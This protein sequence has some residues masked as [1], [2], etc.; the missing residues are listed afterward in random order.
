VSGDGRRLATASLDGAVRVWSL[1]GGAAAGPPIRL[2]YLVVSVRLSPDGRTLL[3]TD[4]TG[5]VRLWDAETS[6]PLGL[7]VRHGAGER[8]AAD[9]EPGLWFHEAAFL[10]DRRGWV[11]A[12]MDGAAI[13][14]DSSLDS[15]DDPEAL[16]E[17]AEAVAGLEVGGDGRLAAA[18]DPAARLRDLRE[19]AA[20]GDLPLVRWFLS[21]PWE[22][23]VTPWSEL[24]VEQY[25]R[26]RLSAIEAV[27]EE[28][29]PDSRGAAERAFRAEL[30]VAFPGHP[31]LR[32]PG[33]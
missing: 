1:P 20:G 21:D 4:F 3:T 25:L 22:R 7:P 23:T 12:G 5:P 13:V 15:P 17:L 2:G 31:L 24:T 33:P 11:T 27:L 8:G 19:S 16:A 6:E 30:E 29:P 10:P 9:G 14:W 18:S 26:H 28:L 32:P